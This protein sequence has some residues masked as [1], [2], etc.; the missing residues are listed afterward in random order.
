MAGRVTAF[1]ALVCAAPVVLTAC[2]NEQAAGPA[3]PAA[4]SIVFTLPDSSLIVGDSVRASVKVKDING[5][6]IDSAPVTWAS[7]AANVATVN[8]FGVVHGVAT[9]AAGIVAKSGA[10]ADTVAISVETRAKIAVDSVVPAAL[11]VGQPATIFGHQFSRVP[12]ANVIAVGG[13][14]TTPTTAD[15]TRL[16]FVVPDT[17]CAPAGAR[18]VLVTARGSTGEVEARVA[19]SIPAVSLPVG[20]VSTLEA[21]NLACL[22]FAATPGPTTFLMIVGDVTSTLDLPFSF[23]LVQSVGDSVPLGFGGF[24]RIRPRARSGHAAAAPAFD[25]WIRR[26]ERA[27]LSVVAHGATQAAAAA[28]PAVGTVVHYNVPV[29]GCA[30][31]VATTG[32]VMAVSA[33]AIIA[34]D[35]AA[36]PNGF[37]ASDFAAIAADFD[38]VVYP[39]DTLHFGSPPD[40]DGNGRVILY[41]TPQ[42]NKLTTGDPLI[43]GG[44]F[45]RGDLLASSACAASNRAEIL[46]LQTPD[47]SHAPSTLALVTR[48]TIAHQME[49]MINAGNRL[50]KTQATVFEETWLDEALAHSAED[51]VGRAEDGFTDIQPLDAAAINTN[52]SDF[53][54]FYQGNL[55][56][57]AAWLGNPGAVGVAD[58]TADTSQAA[59]GASWMLL[60]YTYDQFAGGAPRTLSRA[61]AAGPEAGILNLTTAAG[62]PFDSLVKGMLV[63]SYATGQGIPGLAA[64][65][66]FVSYDTHE[67]LTT[68]SGVFPLVPTAFPTGAIAQSLTVIANGGSYVL[69]ANTAP[70]FAFAVRMLTTG[71]PP[72]ARVYLLRTQ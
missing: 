47:A 72:G 65:D 49:H 22:Q 62:V 7:T 60:R 11:I 27:H 53:A 37:A 21:P 16:V 57:F 17:A 36:A 61:L 4:A 69:M 42:V 20:G 52:P 58:T 33:H 56:R 26:Y 44:F 66:Q 8:A 30:N 32:H 71:L 48:G 46:Y 9:G 24:G 45:F 68:I 43:V 14:T 12:T 28:P 40:I 35:D 19:P 18:A 25:G 5:I 13:S 38:A 67:I 31:A 23:Q 29:Q 15:S 55:L 59:R 1:W 50:F 10:A 3:L 6:L 63:A 54:T 39:T 70:V 64:R 2:H 41:Y 51:F 34:Q